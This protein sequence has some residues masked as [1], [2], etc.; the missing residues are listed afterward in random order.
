[1]SE[2]NPTLTIEQAKEDILA[3]FT[4]MKSTMGFALTA[5][6]I[7]AYLQD[8]DEARIEAYQGACRQLGD[9]GLV[10]Y[11][12]GRGPHLDTVAITR[13]GICTIYPEPDPDIIQRDILTKFKETGAKEGYTLPEFWL[14]R[15]YERGIN[16]RQQEIFQDT[17][18]DMA[19][20]GL[21]EYVA[22]PSPNLKITSLGLE[23]IVDMGL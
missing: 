12:A 10:N 5:A 18:R 7:T 17:L 9:E 8:Q 21:V 6:W 11:R 2:H 22:Y 1:M 14:Q 19:S 13:E 16:E 15:D 3:Q 4:A 20:E 23:R